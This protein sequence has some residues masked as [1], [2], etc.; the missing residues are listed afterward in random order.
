MTHDVIVGARDDPNA[1][2][3]GVVG[4]PLQVRNDA[5]GL[6]HVQLA[7]GFHEVVLGV[8]VPE[9]NSGHFGAP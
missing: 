6:G 9:D 5:L 1:V 7:V 8:D 3:V 2:T 4:E